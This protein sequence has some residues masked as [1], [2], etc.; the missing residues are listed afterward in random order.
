MTE[1]KFYNYC[2]KHNCKTAAKIAIN[3]LRY[4]NIVD[5]YVIYM[6]VT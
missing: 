5:I 4:F 2:G 6:G 1:L 3:V